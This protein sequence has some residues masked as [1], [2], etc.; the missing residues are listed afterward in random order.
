M[1]DFPWRAVAPLQRGE[2]GKLPRRL[3]TAFPCYKRRSVFRERVVLIAVEPA[4]ARFS[5][6]NHGM[7]A[8]TRMLGRVA[9]WRIVATQGRAAFL[10]SAQMHPLSASLHALGTLATGSTFDRR[11]R[12]NVEAI[13]VRHLFTLSSG[14]HAQTAH[15]S[16]LRRQRKRHV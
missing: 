10:T 13:T 9:A 1:G 14:I 6:C 15:S 16:R 11:D 4:L 12:G 3:E 5:R 7:S 8:R 2:G